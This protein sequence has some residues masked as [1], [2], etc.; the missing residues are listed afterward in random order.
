MTTVRTRF[1]PSPTGFIHLGNIR[2]ALYPWAFARA[3][4]GTSSGARETQKAANELAMM[5]TELQRLVNRFR[6]HVP[7]AR[8]ER[9][10]VIPMPQPVQH[11]RAA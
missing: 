9:A 8:R 3:T 2:S 1:A 5:A 4:G 11:R 6:F 7:G 10:T